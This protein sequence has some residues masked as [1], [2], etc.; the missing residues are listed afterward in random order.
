MKNDLDAYVCLFEECDKP[1][2]LYN[3]SEKWLKHMRQHTLHW[4]CNAKSHGVQLFHSQDDYENHMRERH[5]SAFTEA[6]LPLLA[7]T[8]ARTAE[9]IFKSC[10]LCGGEEVKGR[11]EDHIVGHLRFL[12]LKSLP[13]IDDGDDEDYEGEE[14]RSGTIKPPSRSTIKAD[15][16]RNVRPTF[17]DDNTYPRALERDSG[18]S[19]SASPYAEW[20]GHANYIAKYP[21]GLR[22]P[23]S[24]HGESDQQFELPAIA[25]GADYPLSWPA[26]QSVR[27]VEA[28]LFTGV[29]EA[30]LRQ[31]EWGLVLNK[32]LQPYGG[33]ESDPTLQS[34]L[35]GQ[36]IQTPDIVIA[37]MGVTGAGKSSFIRRMTGDQSIKVGETLQSGKRITLEVLESQV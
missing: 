20:G 3:H 17:D 31:F 27:F 34:F 8:N 11:L 28:H 5:K 23:K 22:L 6:Q 37:V 35:Q 10:P 21:K 12:A 13:R 14:P 15:P 32:I 24:L 36:W 26:D 1:E 19:D 29:S 30:D 9:P 18:D 7:E 16:D 4:R 25:D 2:E 33:H